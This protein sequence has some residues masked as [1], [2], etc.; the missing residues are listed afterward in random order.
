MYNN[1]SSTL[2]PFRVKIRRSGKQILLGSFVTAEE[3]ALVLA[4]SP[5]GQALAAEEVAVMTSEEARQQAQAEGLTLRVAKNKAGY[6]GVHLNQPGQ[7]KPYQARVTRGGKSVQLG[8]FANAEEA[9]LCIARSPE[10]RKAA[11]RVWR[12]RRPR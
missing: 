10:G 2:R 6:F 11:E 9:A 1:P 12:R 7:P 4:R 8:S 3:A 5:E